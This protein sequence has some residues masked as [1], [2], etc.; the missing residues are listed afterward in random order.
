MHVV[1]LVAAV[2][3]TT[4]EWCL[5][6]LCLLLATA[7]VSGDVY[8]GG[9]LLSGPQC[10]HPIRLLFSGQQITCACLLPRYT[11]TRACE[12]WAL[13]PADPCRKVLDTVT[14]FMIC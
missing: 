6:S 10:R 3:L 12:N 8:S 4:R 2:E 5:A 14:W 11:C 9:H 1:V 13:P 7:A